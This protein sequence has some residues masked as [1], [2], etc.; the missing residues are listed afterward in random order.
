ML[1]ISYAA[2]K[3][4]IKHDKIRFFEII[5]ITAAIDIYLSYDVSI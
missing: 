3:N 1:K 2:E 4:N 5:H